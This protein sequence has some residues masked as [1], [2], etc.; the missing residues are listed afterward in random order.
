MHLVRIDSDAERDFVR[1]TMLQSQSGSWPWIGATDRSNT[2]VWRWL[3]GTV[4]WRGGADGTAEGGA[5]TSWSTG[6]P[7]D[8]GQDH[9]QR[10]MQL[11]SG[12]WTI[13]RARSGRFVCEVYNAPD[14]KCAVKNRHQ[15]E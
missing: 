10:C 9:G 13:S 12:G 4:F 8:G 14:A 1:S 6:Q 3:D 2:G 11:V 7:S 5:Y 15:T